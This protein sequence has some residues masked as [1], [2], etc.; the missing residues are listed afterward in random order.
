VI[1]RNARLIAAPQQFKY[2]AQVYAYRYADVKQKPAILHISMDT[3]ATQPVALSPRVTARRLLIVGV[4]CSLVLALSG[5][6]GRFVV[7]LGGLLFA[8]GYLLERWLGPREQL[9]P[10]ARPALWLALSMACPVLLLAW[11]TPLGLS[12]PA[13]LWLAMI[14]GCTAAALMSVWYHPPSRPTL[15]QLWGWIGLGVVLAGTLWVRFVQSSGLAFPPWV[16]SVH[17]ALLIRIAGEQGRAPY[18]LEPYLPITNLP[19]H[20]GYHAL[21]AVA[22][23]VSELPLPDVMLWAGQ[24]INALHSLTCAAL[25]TL[26]WRRPLAGIAAAIVVGVLSIMPAY[27]LSWGRYTQ[28]TGLLLL[29]AI[30]IC[31][32]TWLRHPT[33]RMGGFVALLLAALSIIHFRVLLMTLALLGVLTVLWLLET[34]AAQ[35]W[36]RARMALWIMFGVALL[37]APWGAVLLLERLAPAVAQPTSLVGGGDY[38]KLNTGLLWAGLTRWLAA[39]ALLALAWAVARRKRAAAVIVFWTVL[40]VLLANPGLLPVL[41]PAAGLILL[42]N[43]VLA[44]RWIMALGGGG[45]TL[46]NPYTTWVP[47]F[48]LMTNEVIVITLFVP[49]ALALSGG[50][51]LAYETLYTRLPRFQPMLP[52]ATAVLLLG[53]L[54]WGGWQ[55]RRVV[56]PATILATPA[57]RAALD[58]AATNTPS[59]ARFLINSTLWFPHLDRGTDGG[60]WLLPYIGRFSSLPPAIYTYGTPEYVAQVHADSRLVGQFTAGQEAQLDDLIAR[61]GLTHIYLGAN[62]APLTPALFSDPQR[63]RTV[64]AQDGIVIIEV[65]TVASAR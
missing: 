51:V 48:W 34:P 53:M 43:G 52:Y 22:W 24:I 65:R 12:M 16:D 11:T 19:Y 35:I 41:L 18:N 58:W 42:I 9:P 64:Y 25:A 7:L 32:H 36:Q 3:P 61:Q 45:L 17:H 46:L 63:F 13:A 47:Y 15:P 29:P 6:L 23:Q 59:D 2:L 26:L 60:Y 14:A 1:H 5:P 54:V 55:G 49:L 44:R 33:R 20:W 8:P 27:Y 31:W 30:A 10:F 57:D 4:C 28:L 40:L 62:A 50:V 37:A 56:N 39:G 38:N 21:L